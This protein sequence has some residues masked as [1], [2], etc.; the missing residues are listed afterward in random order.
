MSKVKR[1]Q[2][3]VGAKIVVET[4]ANV[5]AVSLEDAAIQAKELDIHDFIHIQGEHM[6]SEPVEIRSIYKMDR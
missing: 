4:T 5:L 2:Y 1:Q 6:D 3:Q